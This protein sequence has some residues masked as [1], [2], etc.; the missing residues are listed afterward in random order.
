[1]M[2]IRFGN[3][4]ARPRRL[5]AAL[6]AVAITGLSVFLTLVGLTRLLIPLPGSSLVLPWV[7]L[8]V[9]AALVPIWWT[10]LKQGPAGTP[11]A[12]EE[13]EPHLRPADVSRTP[14]DPGA[15][16]SSSGEPLG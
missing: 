1:M 16:S 13:A 5:A 15:P 14:A 8:A 2:R 10:Q 7:F 11:A 12:D 3:G 9:G 4:R 6:L